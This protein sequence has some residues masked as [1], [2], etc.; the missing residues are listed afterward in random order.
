MTFAPVTTAPQ[1]GPAPATLPSPRPA[2]S[3]S[4]R[5][6][7]AARSIV[8]AAAAL[9][10]ALAAV[11]PA[12]GALHVERI[13][14]PGGIAAWTVYNPAASLI[15][16]DFSFAGGTAQDPPAKGGV[17]AM[18]MAL[19]G[20]GAGDVDSREFHERIAAKA[21]RLSFAAASDYVTGS[22]RTL[23]GNR[24]EAARLLKLALTAP[25]F[26]P[27]DVERIRGQ[28]LTALRRAATTPDGLAGERWSATAFPS[29]PYGRPERGTLTT[30]PVITADDLRAYTGNVLARDNLHVAV[31]GNIDTVAAGRLID[32]VF[33]GLPATAA[34]TPVPDV[35]AQGMG[36]QIM[37]DLDV[38]QSL[39]VVGG[40]G[41]VRTDPD[42]MA[43]SVL[44]HILGDDPVA[45]RLARQV[46]EARGLAYTSSSSLVLMQHTGV[47][48]TETGTRSE[49]A[50]E[51]VAVIKGEIRKLAETGPTEDELAR[52]K[53]YM[54]GSYAL[55]FDTSAKLSGALVEIQDLGLGIDYIDRRN[56][57]VNAVTMADVKRV[58]RR[59]FGAGMLV[60]IVGRLQPAPAGGE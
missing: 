24:D 15:A 30:V 44:N 42:F 25:R 19:L 14:S 58:A 56:S 49:R 22:L 4:R 47:L 6:A 35:V 23:T 10:A 7:R 60:T 3:R 2:S 28:V 20:E 13:V 51:A 11:P 48:I 27:D 39:I 34:L 12:A 18:A 59:L 46:R 31:V 36:R 40:R 37:V 32:E 17:A 52:A 21:I 50:A 54:T 55:A 8:A 57:L 41:L 38:P 33:G 29:H 9:F 16:L 45:S 1:R 5:P 53:S 26:D 43:A